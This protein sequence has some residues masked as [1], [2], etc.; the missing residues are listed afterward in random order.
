VHA[1]D[2]RPDAVEL[3]VLSVQKNGLENM[4]FP[5]CA[6]ACELERALPAAAFDLVSCNPP[7]FAAGSGAVSR[8]EARPPRATRT[9]FTPTRLCR[10]A[11]RLLR[12]GGRLS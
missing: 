12:F 6:D 11:K 5:I 9:A 1:V 7:Y 8:R 4:I 10:S 3:L 2:I